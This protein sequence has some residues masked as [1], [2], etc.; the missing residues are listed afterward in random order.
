MSWDYDAEREEMDYELG[1]QLGDPRRCPIHGTA[2]SSPDGMFDGLC[3]SCETAMDEDYC[4]ACAQHR[5][6]SCDDMARDRREAPAAPVR[7][8]RCRECGGFLGDY[9]QCVT[10]GC[11]ESDD[12]PF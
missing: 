9:G 7:D 11:A 2:I 3:G 5:P 10:P 8:Q 6:C 1:A 4:T 12:I